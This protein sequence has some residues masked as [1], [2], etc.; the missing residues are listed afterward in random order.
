MHSFKVH[1]NESASRKKVRLGL[2]QVIRQGNVGVLWWGERTTNIGWYQVEVI[3]PFGIGCDHGRRWPAYG[4]WGTSER[5]LSCMHDVGWGEHC[6]VWRAEGQS[7]QQI[8]AR[9]RQVTQD[10]RGCRGPD[11]QLQGPEETAPTWQVGGARGSRLCRK[12]RGGKESKRDG[13]YQMPCM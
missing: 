6:T 5:A 4:R 8:P 11:E 10:K 12:L 7:V 1:S 2:E 3:V 13:G 9:W